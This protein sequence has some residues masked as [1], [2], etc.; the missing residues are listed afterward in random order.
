MAY[1]I[2]EKNKETLKIRAKNCCEY[3]QLPAKFTFFTFEIDHIISQK[4]GGGHSL[5]NL[6]YSC[7]LCN[8]NKGSDIGSIVNDDFTRFFNPRKDI[9]DEHFYL[10]DVIIQSL[11]PI[12]EATL[13]I[14]RF[15]DVERIMERQI[16]LDAGLR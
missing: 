10:D 8:R 7:P 4:H 16:L 9:W 5:I 12:G 14:L 11:T 15:N 13:K 6:A 2:S 3:C 1:Y